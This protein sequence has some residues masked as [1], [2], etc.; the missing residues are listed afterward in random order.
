M[1]EINQQWDLAIEFRGVPHFYKIELNHSV[2]SRRIFVNGTEKPFDSS[3]KSSDGFTEDLIKVGGAKIAIRIE[4][5]DEDFIYS[6]E[7]PDCQ[8]PA[9]GLL[10]TGDRGQTLKS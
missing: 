8:Q 4:K 3:K 1:A 7:H 9:G 2:D 10:Q 6:V 5:H